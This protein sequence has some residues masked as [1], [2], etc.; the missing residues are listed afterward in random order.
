MSGEWGEHYIDMMKAVSLDGRV[1]VFTDTNMFISQ[2][3]KHLTMAGA[4]F[5]SRILDLKELLFG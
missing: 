1:R 2:D 4:Q 3:T 5:Y